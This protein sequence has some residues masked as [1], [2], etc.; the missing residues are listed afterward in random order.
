MILTSSSKN[1]TILN[2]AEIHQVAASSGAMT[3]T[4]PAF[5]SNK[6]VTLL[7]NGLTQNNS[8]FT[9]T[10]GTVTLPTTLNIIAGDM[11]TYRYYYL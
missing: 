11:I 9:I 5:A 3:I 4:I 1:V 6:G 10:P 7:I 8:E 2:E